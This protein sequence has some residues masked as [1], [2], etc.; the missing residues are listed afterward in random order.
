MPDVAFV[1]VSTDLRTILPFLDPYTHPRTR[2]HTVHAGGAPPHPRAQT[3]TAE[4]VRTLQTHRPR[5]ILTLTLLL[6]LILTLALNHT[7]LPYIFSP[8]QPTLT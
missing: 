4:R 2:K 6:I 5:V 3:A 7:L 8:H 1:V